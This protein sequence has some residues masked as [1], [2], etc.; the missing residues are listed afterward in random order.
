M[1]WPLIIGAAVV[2]AQPGL[3]ADPGYLIELINA[4]HVS[5]MN[6]VPSYLALFLERP[7]AGSCRSLKRMFCVGETLPPGLVARF[8]ST[9][10]DADLY[11]VYGLTET[12]GFVTA[13]RCRPGDGLLPTVPIGLPH[14]NVQLY[15]LDNQMEPVAT[16]VTGEIYIAGVKLAL[17]YLHRPDLTDKAFVP[18]P[19]GEGRL[20]KTGDLACYR[21]D[22]AIEF[23]G[24]IDHQVNCTGCE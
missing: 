22:G 8:F 6:L 19:F 13:W 12:E 14:S 16:G 11:N 2:L 1:F 7:K 15:I 3:E 5:A 17:G 23:H 9:L 24:R 18:N 21:E 10:P 20:Y 4:Q